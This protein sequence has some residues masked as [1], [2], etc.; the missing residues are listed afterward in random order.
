MTVTGMTL[1]PIGV[2]RNGCVSP[3]EPRDAWREV[4]SE[5]VIEDRL[6]DALE[7]IEEFSHIVVLWWMH[8]LVETGMPLRVHPGRR[9]DAPLKGIFAVR[10]P[11]RPNPIGKSTVRLL[12]RR[13]NVVTVQGLDALDGSPVIDIKPFIPAIDAP[14]DATVPAWIAR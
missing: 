1:D 7:G 9:P 12:G 4:I 14:S 5:I 6:L 8:N 2:V 10:T 13:G 11:N 3:P